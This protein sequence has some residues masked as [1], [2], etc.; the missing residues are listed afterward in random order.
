MKTCYVISIIFYVKCKVYILQRSVFGPLADAADENINS[1]H[2]SNLV[3]LIQG[4]ITVGR[5]NSGVK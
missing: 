1:T 2:S 3:K 4:E 5:N